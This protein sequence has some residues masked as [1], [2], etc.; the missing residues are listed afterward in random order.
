MPSAVRILG[1]RFH[2]VE[3]IIRKRFLA[4]ISKQRQTRTRRGR[5]APSV[6]PRQHTAGEREVGQDLKS[7]ALACGDHLTLDSS[8][9]QTV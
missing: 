5:L 9:E 1:E 6:F 2:F 7:K 3:I 8:V 4:T